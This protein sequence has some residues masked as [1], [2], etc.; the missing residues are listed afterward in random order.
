VRSEDVGTYEMLWDCPYCGTPKLLGLT[1]RH[2]P[3]CGGAQDPGRRYYPSDADKVAVQDHVYAGA[4]KVCAACGSPSGGRAEFCG[5]CGGPLAGAKEAAGRGDQVAA[6][7]QAFAGESI[8]DVQ[9]EERARRQAL[10]DAAAGKQPT[11]KMSRGLRIALV[12]G[13]IVLLLVVVVL[14][15]LLWKREVQLT[16]DAMSWKRTIDVER[17]EGVSDSEWCDRMPS[18]AYGVSRRREVREHKKVPDGEECTTRR[19]DNKDGTFKEKQECTP[20]Y[21][22][23]PVYADKCHFTIDKWHTVRTEESSGRAKSPAPSWPSPSLARTGQC[24]GCEREGPRKATYT[25]H[26]VD[27]AG[28]K[29]HECDVDE[30]KWNAAEP[31]SKWIAEV[32]V[33]TSSLDCDSIAP[34]P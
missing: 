34:A 31:G 30:A 3:N 14:V 19:V 2:C 16:L 12:V 7:G 28:S 10:A 21:R 13:G 11:K 27:T 20:K 6:M 22:E 17:F 8:R 23:E 18:Q 24:K 32:G 1:H 25:L 26:L 15:L 33:V 4:D 9:A 5:N 29:T